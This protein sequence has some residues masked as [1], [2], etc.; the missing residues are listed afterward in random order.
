VTNIAA[1]PI[2]GLKLVVLTASEGALRQ[3]P[4]RHPFQ[5]QRADAADLGPAATAWVIAVMTA[6]R[7]L[8][9]YW[10]SETWQTKW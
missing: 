5:G 9:L 10:P 7:R 3:E 4:L 8:S 6:C 1:W 2:S